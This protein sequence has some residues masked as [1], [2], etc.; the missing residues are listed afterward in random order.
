MPFVAR[1]QRLKKKVF[2]FSVF[3]A[4]VA[5]CCT[6]GTVRLLDVSAPAWKDAVT[7]V[8]AFAWY[9][10]L[11]LS[12]AKR[13][14]LKGGAF[15][16]L[17]YT[18]Y[19][20]FGTAFFLFGL[21]IVRG[22]FLLFVGAGIYDTDKAVAALTVLFS[23]YSLYGGVKFPTLKRVEI[24]DAK[25]SRPVRIVAVS[26]LHI[27]ETTPVSRV[28]K[29]VDAVNAQKPD[30]VVLPGDIVDDTPEKIAKQTDELARIEARGGVFITS[31]N[32]ELYV[33]SRAWEERFSRLNLSFL[34]MSGT[35][36]SGTNVYL[37]GLPDLR[38]LPKNDP[39]TA[40]RINGLLTDKPEGAYTVLLSHSPAVA[41]RLDKDKVDLQISGHTHGG[42]LFPFH[43]I[44]RRFN[45]G[46]L[47]G[48]YTMAD[49][50]KLYITRG[51]GGWGPP[52][53]LF[54][55]SEISVIDLKPFDS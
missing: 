38:A 46:F 29:I 53:R 23:L 47:S 36:P 19:F 20:L 3:A 35:V 10:P 50:M 34:N 21:L 26:D 41:K 17:S 25:I 14:G 7:G 15:V 13:A 2:S 39:T 40:D 9:A 11:L 48:L 45:G 8:V 43:W 1:F 54:A 5:F 31:G 18:L 37:A 12:F 33:G 22:V 16:S 42:Q 51:A 24:A 44:V 55:P 28:G 27:N 32:H 49:G 52:M 4:V 30:I 6:V